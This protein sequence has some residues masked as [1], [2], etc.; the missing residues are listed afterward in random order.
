MLRAL[1][2]LTGLSTL[3]FFMRLLALPFNPVASRP[4]QRGTRRYR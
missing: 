2:H 1:Y 3:V 4:G